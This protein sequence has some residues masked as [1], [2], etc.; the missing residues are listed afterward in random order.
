MRHSFSH[1]VMICDHCGQRI[2][3]MRL[4]SRP[5]WRVLYDRIT[6]LQEST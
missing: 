2:T 6:G 1:D 3:R 4:F 5:R